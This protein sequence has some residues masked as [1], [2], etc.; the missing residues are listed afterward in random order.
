MFLERL[1]TMKKHLIK[2]ISIALSLVVIILSLSSC[3]LNVD[4]NG[5][6][7]DGS[8]NDDTND[9]NAIEILENSSELVLSLIEYLN[10]LDNKISYDLPDVTIEDQINSIK[11]GK[12]QP[13][14]LDFEPDNCYFVC[15]YHNCDEDL[16]DK[17]D[18]Y[19]ASKYT[20]VKYESEKDIKDSYNDKSFIVSFQINKSSLAK[21]I[22]TEDKESK[23]VETI[24][25]YTP[26]FVN[27][28]NT[29]TCK[30]VDRT[31]IYLT[32]SESDI[33][34]LSSYK[35]NFLDEIHCIRLENQYFIVLALY[36]VN[37][38]GKRYD[39]DNSWNLGGYYDS[40]MEIMITDK[41]KED[42][43]DGRTCHY[44][45]FNI[46]EFVKEII[47]DSGYEN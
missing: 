35:P 5:N 20:W 29:N 25:I 11:S 15:G 8:L 24:D 38:N 39:Y 21:N 23:S 47:K 40:M 16:S 41:Y 37:A 22:L 10:W 44:G 9:G 3:E 1:K 17:G 30:S 42:M 36:E 2:L 46:D 28:A 27:G 6:N 32:S 45:L 43:T 7:T 14:L 33:I 26:K 13:L 31:Y 34:Y 19:C 18:Y 4:H 12:I